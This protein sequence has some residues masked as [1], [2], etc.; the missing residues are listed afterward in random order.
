[1]T[2]IPIAVWI[3]V[4][5]VAVVVLGYGAYEIAWK[6]KRLRGDLAELQTLAGQAEHLQRR[7]TE[8]QDRLAASRVG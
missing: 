7:L 2:W 6:A 8:I 1:M 3:T 4:G 5:V